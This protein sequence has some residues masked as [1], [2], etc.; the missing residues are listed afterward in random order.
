V[1]L[2]PEFD[3]TTLSDDELPRRMFVDGELKLQKEKVIQIVERINSEYKVNP[4][5][6][7]GY[8]GA[9]VLQTAGDQ[10][11][12]VIPDPPPT[13]EE[14]TNIFIYFDSSGSMNS[15]LSPLNDMRN[16]LL[17][18]ALLSF[19]DNNETEYNNRVNVI[20]YGGERTFGMLNLFNSYPADGNVVVLVF[21]DEASSVYHGGSSWTTSSTRTT[22]FDNDIGLLRN[23]LSSFVSDPNKGSTYYRGVIFQ[24]EGNSNNAF[25]FGPLI[26]AVQN[27]TGNYAPPYGLSDRN[28]FNYSYDVPDGGSA[29]NYLDLVTQALTN[30]GFDLTPNTP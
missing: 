2:A 30:L 3:L 14:D 4:E 9:T 13:I 21:Q 23:N 26:Q 29:Q 17:K 1:D 11:N 25:N 20:S 10:Q 6:I 16:T 19:Y 27:G 15:T 28:E 18:N 7:D 8:G 12:G 22:A 5:V 24:V